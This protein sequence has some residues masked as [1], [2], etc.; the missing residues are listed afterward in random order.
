M[1]NYNHPRIKIVAIEAIIGA[2]KTTLVSKLLGMA[3]THILAED[4]K[5]ALFE[6]REPVQEWKDSGAF[7]EFYRDQRANASQF[8]TYVF[9]TRIGE[10][11]D[12]YAEALAWAE[13]S[14]RHTAVIVSE[15]SCWG[16]RLFKRVMEANGNMT[17]AQARMYEGSF[18][19]WQKTVGGRRP[20]LVIWLR[21]DPVEAKRRIDL[22]QREDE[23]VTLEYLRQLHGQHEAALGGGTFEGAPVMPIDGHKPFHVDDKEVALISDAIASRLVDIF[24]AK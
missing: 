15:R 6:A 7:A 16:D 11:A 17:P 2:G 18:A 22:R 12:R 3:R 23:V 9:S 13:L 21:T 5:C 4:S 1:S 8:Q 14:P 10:F 20:D 24:T 19:A